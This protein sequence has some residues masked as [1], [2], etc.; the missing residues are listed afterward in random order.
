MIAAVTLIGLPLAVL[1]GSSP[2]QAACATPGAAPATP[3]GEAV[4]EI[5]GYTAEQVTNAA[6]IISA[7]AEAG[8]PLRGQVLGVMAAIGESSLRV[9]DYGD[10]AGPDSRGLFQQRDNGA[11]FA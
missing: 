2:S 7:G 3:V 8:V 4:P 5:E 9:L 10:V 6:A 11:G 1:V